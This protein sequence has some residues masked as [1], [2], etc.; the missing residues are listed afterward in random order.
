MKPFKSDFNKLTGLINFTELSKDPLA[1][2][3]Y[4]KGDTKEDAARHLQNMKDKEDANE[5]ER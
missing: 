3:A 4:A 5:K 2:P 1:L